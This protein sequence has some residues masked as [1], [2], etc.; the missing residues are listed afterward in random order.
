MRGRLVVWLQDKHLS[1]KSAYSPMISGRCALLST[2]VHLSRSY[3]AAVSPRPFLACFSFLVRFLVCV[4][5]R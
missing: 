1:P 4:C 3:S 5:I 2:H